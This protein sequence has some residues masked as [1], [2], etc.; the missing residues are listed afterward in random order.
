MLTPVQIVLHHVQMVQLSPPLYKNLLKE[1][2]L[3]NAL[4]VL[5]LKVVEHLYV[6]GT[7]SNNKEIDSKDVIKRCQ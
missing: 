2:Y 4:E 3:S 5:Y 6:L 1:Q 7:L